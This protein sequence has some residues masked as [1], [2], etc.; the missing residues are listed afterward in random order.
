MATLASGVAV[1]RGVRLFILAAP[2]LG[3]YKPL[4]EYDG[5]TLWQDLTPTW[6]SVPRREPRQAYCAGFTRPTRR[7]RFPD[8]R[9]GAPGRAAGCGVHHKAADGRLVDRA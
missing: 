4:S 7:C 1:R 9:L 2:R 5:E 6:S 8:L 3:I